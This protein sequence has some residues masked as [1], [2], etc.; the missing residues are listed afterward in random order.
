MIA[1]DTRIRDD[2]A[3]TFIQRGTTLNLS[4]KKKRANWITP[5]RRSY[6]AFLQHRAGMKNAKGND[7]RRYVAGG[8]KNEGWKKKG[9]ERE[10]ERS[11]S[12]VA[13]H[14]RHPGSVHGPWWSTYHNVISIPV[15]S[16]TYIYSYFFLSDMRGRTLRYHRR[17][18]CTT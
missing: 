8:S 15:H 13:W 16:Y 10:R 18:M 17:T 1:N 12:S 9:R 14:H 6:T 11:K 5:V 3:K 4:A 2:A 7:V